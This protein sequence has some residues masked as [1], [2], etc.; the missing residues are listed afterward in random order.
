M[1]NV[2]SIESVVTVSFD[3]GNI[4]NADSIMLDF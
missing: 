2:D 3:V 4:V 1:R